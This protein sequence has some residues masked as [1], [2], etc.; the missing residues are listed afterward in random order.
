MEKTEKIIYV[1]LVRESWPLLTDLTQFEFCEGFSYCLMVCGMS[2][3]FE[4]FFVCC[5]TG[6]GCVGQI[7]HLTVRGFRSGVIT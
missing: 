7:I 4:N 3:D 5:L 1:W 6:G 2:H